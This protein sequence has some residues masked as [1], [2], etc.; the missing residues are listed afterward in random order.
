VRARYCST[1]LLLCLTWLSTSVPSRPVLAA[2]LAG[3]ARHERARLVVLESRLSPADDAGLRQTLTELLGRLDVRVAPEGSLLNEPVLA[4]VTISPTFEGARVMVQPLDPPGPT[5]RHEVPQASSPELFRETLA[6]VV[7]GA[8]EPLLESPPEPE[9]P[10]LPPPEDPTADHPGSLPEP[11]PGPPLP[12]SWWVGARASALWFVTEGRAGAL[13]GGAGG[14]TLDTPFRPGLA[15][16]AGYLLPLSI[17]RDGLT[18]TFSLVA[19]RLRPSVQVFSSPVVLVRAELAP[20]LGFVSLEPERAGAQILSSEQ[21][22]RIQPML[23][24]AGAAYF[25]LTRGVAAVARAGLDLDFAPRRWVI[26]VEGVGRSVFYQTTRLEPQLTLGLDWS[27][28]EAA[29]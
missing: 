7:L 12:L 10:R 16:E 22:S 5:Q 21:S 28:T 9:P 29:R 20:G 17:E 4:K 3:E 25:A 26:D 19:L 2:E 14:V 8:V 13:L 1:A 15:L 11:P 24:V 27:P 23:G 6:H 18:A